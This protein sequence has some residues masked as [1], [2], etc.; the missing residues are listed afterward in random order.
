MNG[1][2]SDLRIAMLMKPARSNARAFPC[3]WPWTP[4]GG[5]G[6]ELY[7]QRNPYYHKVDGA[8]RQLPYLDRINL[9]EASAASQLAIS[10]S[11]L[12]DLYLLGHDP[13]AGAGVAPDEA[14]EFAGKPTAGARDCGLFL[15]EPHE[16]R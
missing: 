7:L 10:Q 14:N 2:C 12:H 8:G 6:D 9:R 1:S 11:G 5:G 13:T 3:L 4:Q 15:S 16:C